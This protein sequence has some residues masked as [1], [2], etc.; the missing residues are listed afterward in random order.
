MGKRDMNEEGQDDFV[1]C[2]EI[3][4]KAIFWIVLAIGWLCIFIGLM[5]F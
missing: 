4:T 3:S 1:W 2:D 5:F